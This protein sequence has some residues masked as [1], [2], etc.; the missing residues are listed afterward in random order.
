MLSW[1]YPPV[2][3]GGLARH[4]HALSA[5]LAQIG[6]EVHVLTR[7]GAAARA[8]EQHAG[9]MVRRVRQPEFPL[10]DMDAFLPWVDR[11][12]ADML[13]AGGELAGGF[14]LVHSHDWLVAGAARELAR[15]RRLPWVVTVHATEFG[16]H[17]GWVS[18]HPQS[19]IHRAER[20]MVRDADRVI[21]CSHYMRDHIAAAFGLPGVRVEVI[22]NGIEPA[23]APSAGDLESLR[24]RFAAPEHQLVL[25]AGRLAF[26]KGFHLAL[27]A[28][29]T[30][31]DRI[32]G[33]RFVVVGSGTAEADLRAQAERLGLLEHGTFTGWAGDELLGSLYRVA[34]VCVVPSL[35]EPFGLVA[36]E[37][38]AA[39]CPCVVADTGGLR[40]LVPGDLHVGLRFRA[41]DVRSLAETVEELLTEPALRARLAA[42][43]REH[44]L[45]FDWE[46]VALRTAAVYAS[47]KGV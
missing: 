14:D 37:A 43:A 6:V 30:L 27:D 17:Q 29:P 4:V 22:P 34:D 13:A 16:R 19:H 18:R 12:N 32:G 15:Q 47:L 41:G 9:V 21:A 23:G 26:E 20:L 2:V 8:G 11:M 40:E 42:R 31:I 3:A 24:A 7:E 39:G 1:E 44:A 38:M 10:G 33:V 46:D 5:R 36:L 25:L 28:L 45:G 35:Y